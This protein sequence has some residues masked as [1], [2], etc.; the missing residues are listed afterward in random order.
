MGDPAAALP[1]LE[2]ALRLTP[3]D[4]NA[5]FLYFWL[6]DAHLLLG[7]ADEAVELLKKSRAANPQIQGPYI[8]LA[9]ALGYQGDIEGAKAA[10][11]EYQKSGPT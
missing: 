3:A 5:V 10:L 4:P 7:H 6:G 1:H 8:T 9:A 2:K 11:A